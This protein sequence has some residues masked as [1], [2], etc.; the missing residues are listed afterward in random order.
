MWPRFFTLEIPAPVFGEIQENGISLPKFDLI[1]YTGGKVDLGLQYP[2]IFDLSD[3]SAAPTVPLLKDH[4]P[5]LIVGH[6]RSIKITNT[7]IRGLGLISG[8][9][10]SAKEVVANAKNGYQWQLSVGIYSTILDLIKAGEKILINGQSQTGPFYSSRKNILREI[11]FLSLGADANTLAILRANFYKGAMMTFEEWVSS[12][13]FDPSALTPEQLAALQ[14]VYEQYIAATTPPT[15]G[16]QATQP[17]PEAVANA[18]ALATKIMAKLKERVK[19][20][21]TVPPTVP[22]VTLPANFDPIKD[23]R[24][25]VVTEQERIQKINLLAAQYNNPKIGE[26]Y[27]ANT[28]MKEGWTEEKTHL[29][30]LKAARPNNVRLIVPNDN[31]NDTTVVLKAALLQTSKTD[32]KILEKEFTPQVLD[33]AHKR[34]KSR[35][36]LQQMLLEAA[37]AGG[38]SGSPHVKTNLREILRAAFSTID[39]SGTLSAVINVKLLEGYSAVD[40][41]WRLIADI[42]SAND[43]KTFTSYRVIGGFTFEKIGPDGKIPHG[44]MSEQNFANRVETYGKMFAIT[45]QDIYN[46]NLGALTDLPKQIG[47]GGAISLNIAFWTTFL[48][49]SNFFKAGNNNVSTGALSAAGLAAATTVFRKLKDPQGNYILHNPVYVLV[50]PELEPTA[51]SLY[52]DQNLIGG[53][54]TPVP[55]GNQYQGKYEPLVSPFLSDSTIPGNSTTAYYL[56]ADPNDVATIQV[57]FLDGIETPTVETADVDFEQ[58]GIQT[59]GYW[60]WGVA[61]QDPNGGVR[62]TGI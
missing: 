21:T 60:D 24:D 40:D 46:D 32:R 38:Y 36:S 56:L 7:D 12:L 11:S 45:R 20:V 23:Y 1:A 52:R 10:E 53:P 8:T 44:T 30:M 3:T 62:S 28:A 35:I 18:K 16:Q 19:P 29:E 22:P 48:N 39:I 37:Y 9:S 25:K 6:T 51:N 33:A 57:A 50:P 49:N 41:S 58:L 14:A 17:S 42:T 43:F 54:T 61:L 13:N 26:Q 31:A 15:D 2:V 59:R 34:F 27:I 4:N 55:S 5:S 47:R